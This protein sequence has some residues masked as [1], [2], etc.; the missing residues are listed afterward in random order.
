MGVNPGKHGR[1]RWRSSEFLCDG[2]LAEISEN[3]VSLLSEDE[4]EQLEEDTST[5]SLWEKQ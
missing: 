4:L 2:C 3:Y 5:L 1:V